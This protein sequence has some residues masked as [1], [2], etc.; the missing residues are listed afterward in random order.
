MKQRKNLWARRSRISRGLRTAI[1][2]LLI[3]AVLVYFWGLCG[4]PLPPFLD[5]I[6]HQRAGLLAVMPAWWPL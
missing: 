5:A 4:Y 6:R 1:N 2:L 3:A